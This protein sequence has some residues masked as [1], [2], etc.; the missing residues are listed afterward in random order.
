[1]STN[2]HI[3]HIRKGIVGLPNHHVAPVARKHKGPGFIYRREGPFHA[4][5]K[6]QF[7]EMC[8]YINYFWK[9]LKGVT[10]ESGRVLLPHRWV[11]GWLGGRGSVQRDHPLTQFPAALM[12][13][14]AEA[15]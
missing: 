7:E 5:K 14:R 10:Y 12:L 2:K 13:Q 4:G 3:T 11:G 1:M 9:R 8:S 6:K 15:W